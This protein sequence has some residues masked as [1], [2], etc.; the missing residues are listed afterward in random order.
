MAGDEGHVLC[1]RAPLVY[2]VPGRNAMSRSISLTNCCCC[3]RRFEQ[4][5]DPW[6]AMKHTGDHRLASNCPCCPA[7]S[8]PPPLVSSFQELEPLAGRLW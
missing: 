3:C 5:L 6:T 4:K 2:F 1:Q 7:C 8:Q